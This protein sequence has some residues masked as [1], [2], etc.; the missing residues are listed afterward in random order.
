MR[1]DEYKRAYIDVVKIEE[2]KGLLEHLIVY[3]MVNAMLI[4]TNLIY[5]PDKIWFINS[6]L[7]WG[8]GLA[9]HFIYAFFLVERYVRND[10]M[11]AEYIARQ[12][13]K[14]GEISLDDYKMAYR[15]IEIRNAR[16]WFFIH[17]SIYVIVNSLLIFINLFY[18]PEILWFVYPLLGWG[19]GIVIHALEAFK[20]AQDYLIEL[21]ARAENIIRR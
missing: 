2:R 9:M 8:I 6:L 13:A 4:A 20:H 3:V 5:S 7:W 15:E 11:K 21:E 16:K 10:Q 18:T 14:A 19:I 12:R 1:I 17:L